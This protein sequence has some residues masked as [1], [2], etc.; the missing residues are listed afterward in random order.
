MMERKNVQFF[1][2]L[3]SIMVVR[4]STSPFVVSQ[5]KNP[6]K[7][8]S[9]PQ[10]DSSCLCM[11]ACLETMVTILNVKHLTKQLGYVWIV[12]QKHFKAGILFLLDKVPTNMWDVPLLPH[13]SNLLATH[14]MFFHLFCSP[15]GMFVPF[16]AHQF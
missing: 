12:L 6:P 9:F 4:I 2:L 1:H 7:C 15:F 8:V 5:T 3:M 10:W 11:D 14:K 13:T 16:L